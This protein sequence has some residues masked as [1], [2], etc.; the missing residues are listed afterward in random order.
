[1]RT[2]TVHGPTHYDAAKTHKIQH[3]LFD[4]FIFPVCVCAAFFV[5]TEHEHNKTAHKKPIQQLDLSTHTR[6]TFIR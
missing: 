1:M 5:R 2:T 4:Q 3:I 6:L